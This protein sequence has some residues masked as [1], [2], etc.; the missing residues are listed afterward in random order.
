MLI[1]SYNLSPTLQDQLAKVESLRKKI[2]L[3][4]VS[5]RNDMIL[6]WHATLAHISGWATL[7]NQPLTRE[8]ILDIINSTH[9]KITTSLSTKVL[10]YKR[11][12]DT[13][14]LNWSASTEPATISTILD[15][16]KTLSVNHGSEKEIGSLLTYLQAGEVNPLIQSAMTHLYFYP[17]RLSY[18]G[19]LLFLA[20]YGYD[21][22]G[23]LSLEDFWSHNRDGYL[24]AIQQATKSATVT[25]WLEYF[26]QAIISQMEKVYASLTH[27]TITIDA[28]PLSFWSLTDRQKA[29]V[30]QL[31]QPNIS[32]A[33]KKIQL[34]FKVS[35][36]TASR[37]LAKLVSLGLIFP[38]G[39]G[40]S[41]YYTRV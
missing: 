38:H 19:S 4:P 29:I 18:L 28:Q 26:C 27:P 31:N 13:I 30:E 33:N 20:K 25:L 10:D 15:L 16:A 39:H 8:A 5:P 35:Q 23:W 11:C 3:T 2:L 24:K 40:R 12:L 34:L 37:D 9:T 36:I 32:I 1:I 7:S 6:R 22:R 41:T 21:L 17:S 14:Y